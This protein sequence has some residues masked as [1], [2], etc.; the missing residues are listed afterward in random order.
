M[1][2][3]VAPPGTRTRR[4]ETFRSRPVVR[5]RAGYESA[6]QRIRYEWFPIVGCLAAYVVLALAVFWPIGPFDTRSLPIAGGGNPAGNDPFQMTWFLTYV[7]YAITHGLSLFHS[8]YVD[9]PGG[10]NLADNTSV[11]LLG[12]LA[13]PITA[14]L[15]PIAA[16]NFL[17]RLCF[18]VSGASMFLVLRRYCSSWQAAFIGGLLYA[19]GP[20]MA[21]QE[22]H[23]DLT[24]VPIPPLLFLFGDELVRRQRMSYWLLGPLIGLVS[25]VQFLTSPD[26]ISG[27]AVMAAII[28]VGLAFRYKHLVRQRLP[29]I[30]KSGSLAVGVFVLL[31]GYPVY[32]MMFGAG[33]IRGPVVPINILQ[34]ARADLLGVVVPTSNQLAVPHFI[35]FIGDYFAGGNLSENGTYLGI[36]LL[37]VLYFVYRRFKS[38]SIV[39]IA[40][41]AAVAAWV[42][43]LGETLSI[44]TWGS[45]VPLPGYLLAHLPLLEDTIPA[46]YALYVLLFVSVLVAIGV[47]RMWLP[48]LVGR[49]FGKKQKRLLFLGGLVAVSVL[50]NI[51]F[52]SGEV[53]WPSSLPPTLERSL[54]PGTVVLPVPFATSANSQAM[55]WQA[56]ADMRFR[57]VGGYANI[58]DP[59][60]TYGQRDPVPLPPWH[61]QEVFSYPKF[62]SLLP[63]VPPAQAESQLL[64]YLNRYHVGAVVFVSEGPVTSEGYWYLIDTVGQPQIVQPGYAVW[65]RARGWP[66]RPVGD[67]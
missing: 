9:Y 35:S 14:T 45:H 48:Q 51:P 13:W 29:Y 64:S 27:C 23:I 12:I 15:G 7:P 31:A 34:K 1:S 32:E 2:T 36:P 28:A 57:I 30:L 46:R 65:L 11:P 37:I 24:F 62:G 19:F 55:G 18:A 26:I 54:A 8:N 16:F 44:G 56:S 38:D 58:I 4:L 20:Y 25:I 21:A 50:P 22:L 52:A 17:I 53:P 3:A 6:A 67:G 59:G 41:L 42:L 60:K 49:S 10:V 61:V 47:D 33:S 43:S 39:R 40:V 63:W 5:E 66:T